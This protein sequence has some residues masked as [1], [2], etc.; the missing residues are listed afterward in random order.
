[1]P[2]S[3]FLPALFPSPVGLCV[4]LGQF[5]D[6]IPALSTL[7]P[8]GERLGMVSH[9]D[10]MILIRRAAARAGKGLLFLTLPSS[11]RQI[12][13]CPRCRRCRLYDARLG[14]GGVPEFQELPDGACILALSD[15]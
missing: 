6:I 9:P 11:S 10:M 8:D 7:H 5:P 14:G 12:L 1:M 15:R 2:G 3:Q 13:P 4:I